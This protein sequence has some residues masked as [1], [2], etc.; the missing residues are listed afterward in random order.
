[1]Q[2]FPISP[3]M[4]LCGAFPPLFLQLFWLRT[5]SWDP[6]KK[7]SKCIPSHADYSILSLTTGTVLGGTEIIQELRGVGGRAALWSQVRCA[8]LG[9]A[10]E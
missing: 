6:S 8:H 1:M 10:E 3:S 9:G 7:I 4:Q 5:P 2:V